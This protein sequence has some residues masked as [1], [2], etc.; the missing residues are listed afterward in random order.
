MTPARSKQARRK[1]WHT[2]IDREMQWLPCLCTRIDPVDIPCNVC[3][4]REYAERRCKA[5]VVVHVVVRKRA[6][7]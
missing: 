5:C 2:C 3:E 7:R 1:P 4:L 6:K